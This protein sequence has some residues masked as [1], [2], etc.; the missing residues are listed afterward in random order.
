TEGWFWK[1][2]GIVSTPTLKLV[3]FL[4]PV[5][6]RFAKLL[7]KMQ[8]IR[9]HTGLYDKEDLL[10]LINNQNRQID[11]RIPE[12]ALKI[13][14]GALT[15]GDKPVRE[16]M[17]PRREIKLVA[18]TDTVGPMLMDELHKSGFS[19]YPVVE[20]PTKEANPKIVGT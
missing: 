11:N 1:F 13:A 9:I 20:A 15:F 6:S 17:T 18:A 2:A 4:Q 3:S 16:I 12:E 10:E 14:F 7:A 19:R 5:L 8:P